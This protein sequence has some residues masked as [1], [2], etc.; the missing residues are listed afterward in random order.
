MNSKENQKFEVFENG[1][2]II[3]EFGTQYWFKGDKQHR[4][5]DLPAVIHKD[6]SREW[7]KIINFIE[8]MI[9]LQ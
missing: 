2:K 1:D 3:D 7:I 6:G 4:D 8:I 5:G 9:N